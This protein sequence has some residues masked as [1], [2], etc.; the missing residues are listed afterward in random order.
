MEFLGKRIEERFHTKQSMILLAWLIVLLLIINIFVSPRNFAFA[1]TAGLLGY[2]WSDNIGWISLN[3]CSD[4][5]SCG[6]VSYAISVDPANGNLSGYAWSDNIGWVSANDFSGCPS[7]PCPPNLNLQTGVM[8]GWLRALAN[9]GGWDGWISLKGSGYGVTKSG[10][11]FS[12][13]AWG[14]DVIG[15]L[16]FSYASAPASLN[17]TVNLQFQ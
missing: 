12:G 10:T 7:T 11:A 3:Y 5:N 13:F 2:A 14:S 9:D 1:A 17:P 15:W 16:D 8:T 4:T 6:T